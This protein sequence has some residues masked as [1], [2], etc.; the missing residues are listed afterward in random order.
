MSIESQ[1]KLPNFFVTE[2]IIRHY[3]VMFKISPRA[4]GYFIRSHLMKN[5]PMTDTKAN[6]HN[7]L[8]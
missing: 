5:L 1:Q 6:I 7:M 4:K 3:R 8:S 2:N